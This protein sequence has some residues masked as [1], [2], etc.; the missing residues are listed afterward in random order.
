MSIVV[1]FQIAD[2]NRARNSSY[3]IPIDRFCDRAISMTWL[4]LETVLDSMNPYSSQIPAISRYR[5]VP[6]IRKSIEHSTMSAS[7][8]SAKISSIVTAANQAA[9]T[10]GTSG[11]FG[12]PPGA[13]SAGR[14]NAGRSR[15]QVS[16]AAKAARAGEGTNR[17]CRQR[18]GFTNTRKACILDILKGR[19]LGCV[20]EMCPVKMVIHTAVGDHVE[21]LSQTNYPSFTKTWIK[22]AASSPPRV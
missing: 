18:S 17:A 1:I 16:R 13:S 20:G 22:P 11:F 12:R 10:G 3:P 21:R 4:P 14:R 5:R 9:R 19:S 6:T 15:S 8:S 7:I 2:S